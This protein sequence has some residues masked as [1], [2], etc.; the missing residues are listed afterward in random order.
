VEVD[1]EEGRLVDENSEYIFTR[2][3]AEAA[4]EEA[5]KKRVVEPSFD[6]IAPEV[7]RLQNAWAAEDADSSAD[8]QVLPLP[9]IFDLVTCDT[10][11]RNQEDASPKSPIKGVIFHPAM[12][13]GFYNTYY[14]EYKLQ[15]MLQHLPTGVD[16]P[17]ADGR[18]QPVLRGISMSMMRYIFDIKIFD[19]L[20]LE[21]II[22]NP[23]AGHVQKGQKVVRLLHL[24]GHFCT[25][26]I[27]LCPFLPQPFLP[28]CQGQ[29]AQSKDAVFVSFGCV[30]PLSFGHESPRS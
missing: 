2:L 17:L 14:G 22:D 29:A 26:I 27:S 13:R 10:V 30:H 15:S 6:T 23:I 12:H 3:E 7:A 4:A 21:K 18:T 1:D 8:G 11:A 19:C 25:L 9:F 24:H 5:A 28:R 20:F 16:V